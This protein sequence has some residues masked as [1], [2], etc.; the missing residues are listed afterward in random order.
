MAEDRYVQCPICQAVMPKHP[1][2]AK[3]PQFQRVLNHVQTHSN[4]QIFAY[5]LK[6]WWSGLFKGRIPRLKDDDALDKTLGKFTK[7]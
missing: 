3:L 1:D 4:L 5:Y 2:L 7:D 6:E